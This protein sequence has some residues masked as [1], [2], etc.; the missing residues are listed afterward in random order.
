LQKQQCYAGITKNRWNIRIH[1]VFRVCRG[2]SV[3]AFA[4]PPDR[5]P[6]GMVFGG[7]GREAPGY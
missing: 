5:E 6:F 1:A 4:L 3:F 7:G 2:Q